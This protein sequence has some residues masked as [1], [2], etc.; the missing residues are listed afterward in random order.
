MS[1]VSSEIQRA[2]REAINE[3]ILPQIQASL[4]SGQGQVPHR[5]WN[6]PAERPEYRF[7]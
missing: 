1:S 5:E 4:R 2:K 6:V 7:E 3:H